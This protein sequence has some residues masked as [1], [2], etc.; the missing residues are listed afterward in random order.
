MRFLRLLGIATVVSG[1]TGPL[2]A[3]DWKLL[4][5]ELVSTDQQVSAR[6]R[7]RSFQTIIPRL[8]AMEATALDGEVQQIVQLLGD[9]R[10]GIRLQAS[11]VIA[12]LAMV[13]S[14]GATV[15]QSAIPVVFDRFN[16]PSKRVRDNAVIAI[17][18]LRPTPPPSAIAPLKQLLNDPEVRMVGGGA[19]GLMRVPVAF[20]D[21]E[22]AVREFLRR[23]KRPDRL[24]LAIYAIG[25]A[26]RA[27]A[28]TIASVS[29]Y[30]RYRDERIAIAAALT[31]E[32][33]GPQAIGALPDLQ[34]IIVEPSVPEEVRA[35]AERAFNAISRQR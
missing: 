15:L 5:E 22:E 8:H 23:E 19:L 26:R 20:P 3:E 28:S 35:I 4:F 1:M 6:A 14:D 25:E 17:I 16:D 10:D 7:E 31:L 13:R 2:V 27:D 24:L 11:A 32:K 12:G 30:L 33:L 18:N 34:A 21:A 9:P 29:Q